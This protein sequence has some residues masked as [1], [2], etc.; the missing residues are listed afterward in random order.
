MNSTNRDSFVELQWWS[1]IGAIYSTFLHSFTLKLLNLCRHG[2][3]P[4][5]PH[6]SE[7]Q[8]LSEESQATDVVPRQ[9]PCNQRQ[10]SDL[11]GE[12]HVDGKMKWVGWR[13]GK[14]S[15]GSQMGKMNGS[16]EIVS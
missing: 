5:P 15:E 13:G 16:F 11:G 4:P 1:V 8:M 9:H 10:S 6:H 3:E 2:T 12:E 14:G 7:C